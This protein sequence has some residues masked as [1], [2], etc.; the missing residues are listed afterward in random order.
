MSDASAGST[1]DVGQHVMEFIVEVD[2]QLLLVGEVW[3]SVSLVFF[4]II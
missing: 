3:R 2:I 4:Q 1:D